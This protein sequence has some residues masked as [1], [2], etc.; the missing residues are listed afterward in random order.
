VLVHDF[1]VLVVGLTVL[2]DFLHA[3]ERGKGGFSGFGSECGA[4]GQFLLLD[5]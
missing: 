4:D 5:V 2:A 3:L 1:E